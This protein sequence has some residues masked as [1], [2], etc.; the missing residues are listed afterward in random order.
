MCVS[1]CSC[2]TRASCWSALRSWSSWTTS[3]FRTPPT[4]AFTS[5]PPSSEP[6]WGVH[7]DVNALQLGLGRGF[8]HNVITISSQYH[9]ENHCDHDWYHKYFITGSR[10]HHCISITISSQDDGYNITVSWYHLG[11]WYHHSIV[12]VSVSLGLG[13]IIMKSSQ[14]YDVMTISE[15]LWLVS[16]PP[17]R[18]SANQRSAMQVRLPGSSWSLF[19]CK[20]KSICWPGLCWP[21]RFSPFRLAQPSLGVSRTSHA[22]L[23]VIVGPVGPYFATGAF[24]PV[25]LLA[26]PRF[27][28]ACRG[29][30]GAYK[31]GRSETEKDYLF[32]YLFM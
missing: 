1:L 4:P 24:N 31:M 21:F 16:V 2:L 29:G 7:T 15:C 5:D 27:V 13:S 22:L 8:H 28:R 9:Y 17:L 10:Y 32:I 19:D 20:N 11:L 12:T 3:G 25:S 26:D 23:F 14:Y 6:R 18:R 30:V